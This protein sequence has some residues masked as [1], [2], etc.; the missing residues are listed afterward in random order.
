MPANL[1]PQYYETERRLRTARTAEERISILQELLSMMPKH[2]GTEKL[3]A[4]LKT[5][6]SKLRKEE[7]KKRSQRRRSHGYHVESEGAAQ[8]VLI[9]PPNTG[10]SQLLATLT[11]ATPEVAPYPF[12]T[13]KPAVGMMPFEDIK[14]Q[15]VDTP[16]VSADPPVWWMVEIIRNADL[17]AAILD[18]AADGVAGQLELV[19]AALEH[20]KVTSSLAPEEEGYLHKRLLIVGSKKDLATS[21]SE[22]DSLKAG[23]S[24]DCLFCTVSSGNSDELEQLKRIIFSALDLV[25]IYTKT[26]GKPPDMDDPLIL[27][28]GST[29]MQAARSLH[30]DFARELKF[31]RCW[32]GDHFKGQR[33]ERSYSLQDKDVIEFHM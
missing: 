26:P 22:F 32:G 29:V 30:K 13:R 25:R 12:T 9:G 1:P 15:L 18:M 4:E 27:Q 33:V 31:A 14:I 6:I 2:K 7:Q 3:Q 17:I 8:V 23:C 21:D 5:K 10:K 24:G 28:K 20:S 11:N 19:W 16:P